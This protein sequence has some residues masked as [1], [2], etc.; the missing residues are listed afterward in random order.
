MSREE[1]ET[2]L[3]DESKLNEIVKAAFESV[4]TDGSG[5]IEE[6]EL[7]VVMTSVARDINMPEPSQ[8]DVSKVLIELDS[9]RDGKVS[10]EEFKVLIRQVLELMLTT[11]N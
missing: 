8:E 9:N 1:I 10:Q 4:D 11:L 3:N 5:Y 6:A 2:I 7:K